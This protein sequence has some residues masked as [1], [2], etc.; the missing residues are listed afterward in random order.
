VAG[1]E[2]HAFEDLHEGLAGLEALDDARR[3]DGDLAQ[4][5]ALA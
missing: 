4:P 2:V 1:V 3:L 5:V